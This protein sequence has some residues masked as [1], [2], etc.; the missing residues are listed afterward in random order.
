VVGPSGLRP[1]REAV[2]RSD[3]P[4]APELLKEAE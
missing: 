3:C 2:T 1:T 4:V